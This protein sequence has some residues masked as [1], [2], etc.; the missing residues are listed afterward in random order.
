MTVL[1]RS[2]AHPRDYDACVV[3]TLDTNG[4]LLST[5]NVPWEKRPWFAEREVV[6]VVRAD[7]ERAA[8]RGYQP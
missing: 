3:D 6:A 7:N 1:V 2:Y 8:L 4:T 5:R